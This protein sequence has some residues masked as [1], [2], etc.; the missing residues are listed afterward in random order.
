MLPLSLQVASRIL[1]GADPGHVPM[2]APQM[3]RRE[4]LRKLMASD[5]RVQEKL[6]KHVEEMIM[7]E[8]VLQPKEKFYTEGPPE[9][10]AAR[11]EVRQATRF[12]WF[13]VCVCRHAYINL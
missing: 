2:P 13:C 8:V 9:L 1:H 10:R 12:G 11:V 4:R 3:E 6:A 5:E 7:E